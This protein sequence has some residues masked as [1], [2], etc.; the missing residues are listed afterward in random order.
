M[1]LAGL[2]TGYLGMVLA[3]VVVIFF[4]RSSEET[5][6]NMLPEEMRQ[7]IQSE[8]RQRQQPEGDFAEPEVEEVTPP[9]E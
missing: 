9:S 3:V 2:A 7:Q 8:Q 5:W 6:M 4:S 1:A